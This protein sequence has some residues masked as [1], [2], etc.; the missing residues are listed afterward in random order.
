MIQR[1]VFLESAE[2]SPADT[3]ASIVKSTLH[4]STV[5]TQTLPE[6]PQEPPQA[7][8]SGDIIIA[9]LVDS[10]Q[11]AR[12]QLEALESELTAECNHLRTKETSRAPHIAAQ[13]VATQTEIT[14]G[15]RALKALEAKAARITS[16]ATSVGAELKALDEQRRRAAEAATI[17]ECLSAFASAE[18]LSALPEMFND[19][20]RLQDAAVMTA[21]LQAL[22]AYFGEMNQVDTYDHSPHATAPPGSVPAFAPR[23]APPRHSLAAATE[24]LELYKNVLDN[25]IVSRF[26][27]ASDA[28]DL[29]AMAGCAR[30]LAAADDASRRLLSDLS[31]A[32]V[33]NINGT[34]STLPGQHHPHLASGAS[35]LVSRYIASRPLFARTETDVDCRPPFGSRPM[36][37]SP[38]ASA[39]TTHTPANDNAHTT[40][41]SSQDQEQ[42]PKR[43]GRWSSFHHLFFDR[44]RPS[45]GDG[46]KPSTSKTAPISSSDTRPARNQGAADRSTGNAL[47][48]IDVG[49]LAESSDEGA[50][51]ATLRSLSDLY[52]RVS[53]S[54]RDEA[55]IMEQ[56]F[57]DAAKAIAALCQRTFDQVIASALSMP[58][59]SPPVASAAPETL[60]THLELLTEAY[61]KTLALAEECVALAGPSSGLGSAEA[62]ADAAC[63]D[64]LL[65]Y[66]ALELAWLGSLGA[67]KLSAAKRTLSREVVLDLMA[68][69]EEAVKRCVLVTHPA[70]DVAFAVRVLWLGTGSEEW[71][72]NGRG[73]GGGVGGCGGISKKQRSTVVRSR[74]SAAAPPAAGLLEQAGAHVLLGLGAATDACVRS[75]TSNALRVSSSGAPLSHAKRQELARTAVD[76]TLGGLLRAVAQAAHCAELLTRHYQQVILPHV[77]PPASSPSDRRTDGS[78]GGGNDNHHRQ[79]FGGEDVAA[80]EEGLAE[81]IAAVNARV[82]SSL[83]RAL[84]HIFRRV[85]NNLAADQSRSDFRPIIGSN[86][87]SP[88]ASSTTGYGGDKRKAVG[89][90]GGSSSTS[91]A[92]LPTRPDGP[93]EACLAASAI[94]RA[95]CDTARSHLHGSNATSFIAEMVRKTAE[96]VEDHAVR[97]VFNFEGAFN[98]RRDLSHYEMCVK[99]TTDASY[100]GLE[101]GI[102][103]VPVAKDGFAAFD[104]L[105][106]LT[107]LLMVPPDGLPGALEGLPPGVGRARAAKWLERRA[108]YKSGKIGDRTLQELLYI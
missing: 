54:L 16:F 98:W 107:S 61:R 4:P 29:D 1:S 5:S 91:A 70:A 79:R 43:S 30:L 28:R 32:T 100:D 12:S 2:L 94:L 71:S 77:S 81:L 36:E 11:T 72:L 103:I 105:A 84:N 64:G 49:R 86:T 27:A 51:L 23:A 14:A 39:T 57:P 65:D 106:V 15:E 88:L 83:D 85:A 31:S 20:S 68:M 69:N 48:G 25:Q 46:F 96:M 50:A 40:C 108:D 47:D 101:R 17:L 97:Y 63:G 104:D 24:L 26:D 53:S 55:V 102:T 38:R 80:C 74:F 13:R 78:N 19:P 33:S 60:R 67:S 99:L 34:R 3:V 95:M 9:R 7:S 89:A 6:T 82:V 90:A 93:T 75:S 35:L 10:F 56:V 44:T 22:L 62:L 41:S 42:A 66:F 45:S 52:R 8:S 76:A 18:D 58:T 92:A 21:K 73:G 59:S 87:P 37:S